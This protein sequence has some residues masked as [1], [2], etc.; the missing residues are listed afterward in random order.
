MSDVLSSGKHD[1]IVRYG[2]DVCDTCI[3][4]LGLNIRWEQA[5]CQNGVEILPSEIM[6]TEKK[7]DV[8]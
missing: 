8:K 4:S 5:W 2:F 7:E 3:N 6:P 1:R